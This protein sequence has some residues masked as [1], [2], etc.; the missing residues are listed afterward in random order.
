LHT[1]SART[2]IIYIPG[3]AGIR[4]NE[5]ADKLAGDVEEFGELELTD[6]DIIRVLTEALS[7]KRRKR[8]VHSP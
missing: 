2:E 5:R 3:R 8:R 4:F 6:G 1:I 7:G